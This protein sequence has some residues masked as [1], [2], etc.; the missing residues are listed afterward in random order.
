M[1]TPDTRSCRVQLKYWKL[2]AGAGRGGEVD[3]KKLGKEQKDRIT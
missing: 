2:N 3:T 1:K